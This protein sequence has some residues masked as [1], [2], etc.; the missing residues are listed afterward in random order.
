MGLAQG[1]I[2]LPLKVSVHCFLLHC[3]ALSLYQCSHPLVSSPGVPHAQSLLGLRAFSTI[4]LIG[5]LI[6]WPF[7]LFLS[8]CS[9]S[10]LLNPLP[11]IFLLQMNKA[12][13]L[14]FIFLLRHGCDLEFVS[15]HISR[16]QSRVPFGQLKYVQNM[17][18][19]C[20]CFFELSIWVSS[21]MQWKSGSAHNLS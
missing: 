16:N 11:S 6:H 12:I 19:V 7:P 21:G 8:Q 10:D 2:G 20:C 18:L 17:L 14:S 3:S 4:L 5:Y 15:F 13:F 1:I 9:L